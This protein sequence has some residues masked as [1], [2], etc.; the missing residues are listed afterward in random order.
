MS[1]KSEL[2][3]VFGNEE[4][5]TTQVIADFNAVSVIWVGHIHANWPTCSTENRHSDY[6]ELFNRWF[7]IMLKDYGDIVRVGTGFFLKE[8]LDYEIRVD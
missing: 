8:K 2:N 3:R 6:S 7:G 1:T 4:Y 5:S